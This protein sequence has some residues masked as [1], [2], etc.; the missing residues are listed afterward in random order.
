MKVLQP[1]G[2]DAELRFHSENIAAAVIP[3]ESR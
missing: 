3:E 2:W 1:Q